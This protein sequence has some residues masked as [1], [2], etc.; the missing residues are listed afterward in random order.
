[1]RRMNTYGQRR[2]L[3]LVVAVQILLLSEAWSQ[4]NPVPLVRG[5]A[6]ND[7]NH[8]RPLLDALDHGFC[9]VEVDVFE[10]DGALLVAHNLKDV[11][12]ARTIQSLYLDPLLERVRQNGG[13]VYPNGPSLMLLVDF[14]SPGDRT[15]AVLRKVLEQYK[16]MLTRFTVDSQV[17]R[18]VTVIISG[19]RP[20]ETVAAEVVRYAAIDG[21]LSDLESNPSRHLMPLV[22]QSWGS[23]FTW[24]G[25]ESMPSEERAKL[26]AIVN[27]A[28]IQG[29]IVRFWATPP[30]PALWKQLLDSGVDLI[31][32]DNLGRFQEFMFDEARTFATQRK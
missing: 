15:Y 11:D 21:R 16:E 5:H 27:Q 8:D 19:S 7:Y 18:A 32:V 14:K 23:V 13:R 22:S 25:R 4:Q 28:H 12:P 29:R 20:I 31:N 3:Y 17:E 2:W 1:M 6:H 9:S 10:V 26:R 30:R 24:K